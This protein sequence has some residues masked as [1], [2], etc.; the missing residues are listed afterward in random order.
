MEQGRKYKGF[1]ADL[2]VKVGDVVKIPRGVPY[3]RD[4]KPRGYT[5]RKLT[6]TV[7]A[8][9]PGWE[10]P[11]TGKIHTDPKVGWEGSGGYL[12]DVEIN[13]LPQFTGISPDADMY[14]KRQKDLTQS[15]QVGDI[16]LCKWTL[17]HVRQS[18]ERSSEMQLA[19]YQVVEK[20]P[21]S[22]RVAPISYDYVGEPRGMR[23]LVKPCKDGFLG[24]LPRS[25]RHRITPQGVKIPQVVRYVDGTP[26]RTYIAT[27]VV[28]PTSI[29]M[30][31]ME[32]R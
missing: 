29:H 22:V 19:F 27:K 30:W 25:T 13:D 3:R 31:D 2:P 7:A 18:T 4:G 16:L 5:G 21:R 9:F 28:S 26:R 20:L 14:E 12:H 15:I 32:A 11:V 17:T 24:Y 6:V 1:C 10:C 8:V 23:H